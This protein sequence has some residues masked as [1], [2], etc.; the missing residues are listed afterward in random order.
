MHMYVHVDVHRDVRVCHQMVSS[1]GKDYLTDLVRL[2]SKPRCPPVSASL[3]V[4]GTHTALPAFG[5]DCWGSELRS[6]YSHDKHFMGW[7][8]LPGPP[9]GDV[10]WSV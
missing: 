4:T 7:A 3:D 2:A 6:S 9:R 5:G 1:S 8:I 10:H